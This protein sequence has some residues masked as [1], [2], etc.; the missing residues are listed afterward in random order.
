MRGLGPVLCDA[1]A[2][3]EAMAQITTP[4]GEVHSVTVATQ[5]G[6][7]EP[8]GEHIEK[9]GHVHVFTSRLTCRMR[10]PALSCRH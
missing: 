3:R 7:S 4:C 1:G 10:D 9:G 2:V 6:P 8:I 5:F